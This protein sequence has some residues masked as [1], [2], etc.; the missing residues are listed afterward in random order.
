MNATLEFG[1]NDKATT[2]IMLNTE[3][4]EHQERSAKHVHFLHRDEAQSLKLSR[5][6]LFEHVIAIERLTI[7]NRV[8][9]A[10]MM[11]IYGR[12]FTRVDDDDIGANE[13]CKMMIRLGRKEWVRFGEREQGIGRTAKMF[14]LCKIVVIIISLFHIESVHL[15]ANVKA[16]F[17]VQCVSLCLLIIQ[18]PY[19]FVTNLTPSRKIDR[20][21]FNRRILHNTNPL[22]RNVLNDE[23]LSHVTPVLLYTQICPDISC[24]N[25]NYPITH[26]SWQQNCPMLKL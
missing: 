3:T 24:R 14:W 20:H 22:R 9:R 1:D 10:A 8:A 19:H 2:E 5:S 26:P 23:P 13:A 11:G 21:R 7:V 17:V 12:I 15:S 6:T 4:V 16:S 25:H 18:L